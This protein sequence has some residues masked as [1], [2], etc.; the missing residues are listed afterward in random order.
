MSAPFTLRLLLCL[1]SAAVLLAPSPVQARNLIDDCSF[2]LEACSTLTYE[3]MM[4]YCQQNCP[5]TLGA[6]CMNPHGEPN[7]EWI[8]CW[9]ND[10]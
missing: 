7:P 1:A 10:F 8:Y 2:R 4:S 9:R 6:A 3:D 5:G